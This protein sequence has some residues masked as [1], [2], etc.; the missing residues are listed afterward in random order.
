MMRMH[1]RRRTFRHR[2]TALALLAATA[3]LGCTA[4]ALSADGG[5]LDAASAAEI[6]TSVAAF[7]AAGLPLWPKGAE[8]QLTPAQERAIDTSWNASLD[9]FCTADYAKTLRAD[10]SLAYSAQAMLRCDG[11]AVTDKD[12]RVLDLKA[13]APDERGNITAH[14][15]LWV[16]E[17]LAC[18]DEKTR[19]FV[20]HGKRDTQPVYQANLR[21]EAGSW[22]IA[23]WHILAAS[24]DESWEEYGPNTRHSQEWIAEQTP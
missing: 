6:K 2:L 20:A 17:T 7:Y 18:W 1:S 23:D 21:Y 12:V 4:V 9:A 3:G 15:E 11:Y 16:G 24:A 14:V 5:Q 22:R 8:G 13:E 10:G 19:I